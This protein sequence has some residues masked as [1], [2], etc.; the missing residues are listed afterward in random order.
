[1]T[2]GKKIFLGILSFL[3]LVFTIVLL[4]YVLTTFVPMMIEMDRL[5]RL[6]PDIIPY[7][8]F[9]QMIPIFVVGLIGGLLQLG[10]LIYFIIHAVNNPQ[11]K[12]EERIMWVIVFIF[13]STLAYPVYWFVRI[14]P[15]PRPDSNFVRT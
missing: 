14:W 11:V 6:E 10:L 3:P 12:G 9:S 2:K 15:D 7:K 13:L 5:Q 4:I 8:F 1:M